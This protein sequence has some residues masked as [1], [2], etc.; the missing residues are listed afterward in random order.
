MLKNDILKNGT[1]LVGLYG[2]AP[3]PPGFRCTKGLYEMR[4]KRGI[5]FICFRDDNHTDIVQNFQCL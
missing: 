5:G 3:P 4:T 2:S 1:S